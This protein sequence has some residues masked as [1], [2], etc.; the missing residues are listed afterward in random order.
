[1][2]WFALRAAGEAHQHGGARQQLLH[3]VH[4]PAW[5][6][7]AEAPVLTRRS[8][9]QWHPAQVRINYFVL[10]NRCICQIYVWN[11]QH[12]PHHAMASSRD[13]ASSGCNL[14]R[15]ACKP[16][17]NQFVSPMFFVTANAN[18]CACLL[19][20]NGVCC[21]LS[22]RPHSSYSK[23][24]A[25]AK[26][27]VQPELALQAVHSDGNVPREQARRSQGHAASGGQVAAV[28]RRAR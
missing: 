17:W 21:Q 23:L 18:T 10:Q 8:W 11:C 1:M 14:R 2:T 26:C 22:L 5:R 16:V 13:V 12:S 24:L 3:G 27:Y 28:P 20:S 7:G 9:H 15:R 25:A 4:D 19:G 6:R